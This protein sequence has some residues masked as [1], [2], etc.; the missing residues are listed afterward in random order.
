MVMNFDEHGRIDQR[1]DLLAGIIGSVMDAIIA[2]DD[3]ERI[4]LLNSAAE[5]MFVCPAEDAIGN[6]IQRF[7]PQRFRPQHSAHVRRFAESGVS[8]RTLAGLGTL[9]GLRATGEEFPIEASV[10]KVDS[11]G[12]KFFAVVVRDLTERHRAEEAARQSEQRLRLAQ[13]AASI[14]TFE[15]NIRTGVITWTPELEAMYGLP[16]GGF[17]GTY[18]AFERLVH[19]EEGGRL[20]ELVRPSLKT[21]QPTKGE[22]RVLWPDGSIHWVAAYWQILIDES[23]QPSRVIGVNMDITERKLS[24]KTL[25]DS[26]ERFRL[27]LQAGKMYAYE[28]DAATDII[29]RSG[30]IANVLGSTPEA[31][32]TRQQLLASVHPDDQAL[33]QASVTECTPERP[34]VQI[35]YRVLR[36]DGSVVW[37]EKIAHGFFDEQGRMLRM[38]GMVA[39]ITGRRLTENKLRE[40]ERAVEGSED[41]IV[42]VDREYRYLIA[43]RKFLKM[44]K[45]T[46]EQVVGHFASDVLNEGFFES[47]AKSKLDECFAGNVVRYET[48]YRYPELGE[49]DISVAYFPVEGVNGIDRAAC[50]VQDI[51][52]RKSAEEAVRESEERLRLAILAGKMYAYE[53]DVAT[54]MLLRS[55]EYVKI[56]GSTEPD[57]FSRSQFISKIHPDDRSKFTDAIARLTPEN[58]TGDLTYRVLLPGRAPMWLK[59]SGRAFFDEK[60]RMLRVIGMVAD[61]TDQKLAEEALFDVNRRL[62]Q[63]LEQERSRIGRE[64]HD[65]VT[66]RLALLAIKLEQL[67]KSPHEIHSRAQE[68]YKETVEIGDDVQALSHDLHSSKLEYLGIVSGMK[69]WCKEFA[70]RQNADIE[71]TSEVAN[72]L[73]L[74]IGLCLFRVVQESLRNAVKH[75]GV[76]HIVVQL[77]EHLNQ[78]H[79][80]VCDAG[81]GFNVEA[82]MK[83]KGIGLISMRERVR[84]VNGTIAIESK[85]MNGTKIHVSVPLVLAEAKSQLAAV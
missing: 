68:L 24:E 2:I 14:G 75:S 66:Q 51:T 22:W 16:A 29:A 20:R 47:V 64:L 38:I 61:V 63:A 32:L 9:W 72:R 46:R 74:E 26:E 69:S 79:L 27:A 13:Q 55:P 48:K 40:Y 8:Y 59:N 21:G 77:S 50:I 71:F 53:W 82:A 6:S 78:V 4:V 28:W 18:A 44:R 43:N 60:G 80:T 33:F 36:P 73:P 11:G 30:D 76:K 65:D 58:P 37:L 81:K 57:R 52:E 3:A 23:G 56:L 7:I 67:D 84:L 15:W 19:P 83:D 41:M 54:D 70:A 45:L 85:P 10:S 12:R 42:V 49:R 39:D 62:I 25:R 35:S 34:D 31:S 1:P 5:R 17:D